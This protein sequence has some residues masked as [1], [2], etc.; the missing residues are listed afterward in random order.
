MATKP[1]QVEEVPYIACHRPEPPPPPQ[2]KGRHYH[3]AYDGSERVKCITQARW[4]APEDASMWAA[5]FR[6][7]PEADEVAIDGNHYLTRAGL[8]P[9]TG[10]PQRCKGKG[11]CAAR[12][13]AAGSWLPLIGR[14][15][16]VA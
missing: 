10:Q 5:A 1:V 12:N 6:A 4:A 14:V 7:P 15:V 11:R 13:P 8:D 9:A 3:L 16:L 2:L